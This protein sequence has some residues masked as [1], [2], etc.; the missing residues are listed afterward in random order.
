MG[1]TR[2]SPYLPKSGLRDFLSY[3]KRS[4]AYMVWRRELARYAGFHPKSRFKFLEVGCGPGYFLRCMQ[5]WFPQADL[6][7]LDSN[8][9][10]VTFSSRHLNRVALHHHDGHSLPFPDSS[11]DVLAALQVV[12][13]LEEPESFFKE[14][15]RVL[16]AG[17]ILFVSTPNP[18]GICARILGDKWQGIR[19]D[20]I[21]LKN[22]LQW[23]EIIRE[24]GFSILRDGTTGLTGISLLRMFPLSLINY[25]PMIA[26]GFLPWYKGE[27]YMV[28]LRKT[29]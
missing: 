11:F 6:H 16:K 17:G 2:A 25:L 8:K 4:V 26:F 7:G 20:H 27:S 13:H 9:S 23:R 10:L 15:C 19:N 1:V 28:L 3:L 12:E 24:A 14:S 29:L 21:S 22:P 5:R 18:S